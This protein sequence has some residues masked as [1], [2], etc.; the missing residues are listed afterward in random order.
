MLKA[1]GFH[2][3]PDQLKQIELKFRLSPESLNCTPI[4]VVVSGLSN[5]IVGVLG[6][7]KPTVYPVLPVTNGKKSWTL[8]VQLSVKTSS[9][10]TKKPGPILKKRYKDILQQQGKVLQ[11]KCAEKRRELAEAARVETVKQI[12]ALKKE[13]A[14]KV[15]AKMD[16][17]E[18]QNKLLDE[19]LAKD[20]VKREKR[21]LAAAHAKLKADES[22]LKA[23]EYDS[24]DTGTDGEETDGEETDGESD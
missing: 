21:R 22:K 19:E 10:S 18:E 13:A 5:G 16:L 1:Q 4:K 17:T 23:D 8:T 7:N 6:G 11:E 9:P 12:D 2:F 20:D 14:E 15:R 24:D 3:S